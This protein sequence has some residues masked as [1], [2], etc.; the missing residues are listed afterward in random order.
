MSNNPCFKA[1][2]KFEMPEHLKQKQKMKTVNKTMLEPIPIRLTEPIEMSETFKT[3]TVVKS[4][5]TRY[6]LNLICIIK[7]Y[8]H[9]SKHDMFIFNGKIYAFLGDKNVEILKLHGNS[10]INM[11]RFLMPVD[12]KEKTY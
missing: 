2:K 12:I 1:L 11:K 7:M 10:F 9:E 6:P 8:G 5:F 4:D 3:P